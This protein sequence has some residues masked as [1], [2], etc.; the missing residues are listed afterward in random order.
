MAPRRAEHLSFTKPGQLI[1]AGVAAA[2][3]V[4]LLTQ[5]AYGDLPRLPL[6]AGAT[7][8]LIALVDLVLALT[9]RPRIKRKPGTE[10]VNSLTAARA[11]A[12][13]K[14]SSMA[15]AIMAGVWIGLGAYLLPI[16]GTVAA[17]Q[18]DIVAAVIGL[19]S[20]AALIAAGLWLEHSLRNPDEP[21]EPLDDEED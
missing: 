21:E 14:A 15:G 9:M 8:L 20:A 1:T 3:V 5:L 11:V 10:P 4:F 6:A 16:V 19:I 2:V 12:L 7:L 18:T 17:A 13:A